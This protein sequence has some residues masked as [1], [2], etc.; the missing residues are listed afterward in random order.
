MDIKEFFVPYEIAQKLKKIGFKEKCIA[1]YFTEEDENYQEGKYD[2]RKKLEINYNY[3][4]YYNDED[5]DYIINKDEY[6]YYISAPTYEQVL[7]W[8]LNKLNIHIEI[9]LEEKHPYKKFFYKIRKINEHFY[10]SPVEEYFDN[11]KEAY[12]KS[13]NYIIDNSFK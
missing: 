9:L 7:D 13:F 5:I 6:K 2:S 4:E 11:K 1:S 12:L 8:F 3:S 10:F